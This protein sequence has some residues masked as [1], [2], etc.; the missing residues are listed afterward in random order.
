MRNVVLK[1]FAANVN[2]NRLTADGL[3]AEG[4][5]N[6]VDEDG[7]LVGIFAIPLSGFKQQQIQ[8]LCDGMNQALGK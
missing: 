8:S 2:F 4:S 3:R 7:K 5:F 6:V 1:T